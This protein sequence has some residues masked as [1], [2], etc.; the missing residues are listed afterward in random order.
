MMGLSPVVSDLFRK[1][2]RSYLASINGPGG[3]V[4]IAES[5]AGVINVTKT[6]EFPCYVSFP[7]RDE[8]LR[9]VNS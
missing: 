3:E 4:P 7:E 2:L 6:L 1:A 5:R 9:V 8:W